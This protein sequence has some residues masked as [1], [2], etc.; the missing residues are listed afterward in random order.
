MRHMLLLILLA[1]PLVNSFVSISHVGYVSKH[2]NLEEQIPPAVTQQSVSCSERLNRRRTSL[3]FNFGFN[4]ERKDLVKR[5][6]VRRLNDDGSPVLVVQDPISKANI[7]LVGVSHN[8]AASANLVSKTIREVKPSATVLELCEDRFI[9]ISLDARIQ[10]RFNSTLTQIYGTKRAQLDEMEA[11]YKEI[12][13]SA[14]GAWRKFSSILSF[15]S[16]QGPVGGVFVFLGIVVG[17]LQK[18]ARQWNSEDT[19]VTVCDEFVVAMQEAE[20]LNIPVLLGDAPQNDTLNSIKKLFTSEVINPFKVVRNALFLGFSAFGIFAEES[21]PEV[22][23]YIPANVMQESQWISIPQVY[24][25]DK[26]L[27]RGLLPFGAIFVFTYLLGFVLDMGGAAAMD[28]IQHAGQGTI[29]GLPGFGSG[30]G[31]GG[32]LLNNIDN[33]LSEEVVTHEGALIPFWVYQAADVL[34]D[35][36]SLLL[37]IRMAKIIGTD[38]DLIIASKVKEAALK[39]PK[40]DIVVVIGM[41]HNNGVARWILSGQDPYN[42]EA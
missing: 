24:C 11:K 37:L 36:L 31:I 4:N 5:S 1:V 17:N 18:L 27:M 41:L 38:R 26:G 30:S 6:E 23:K 8:S 3:F 35:S 21:Y 16:S 12:E 40:K 13:G 20:T 10:P 39:Y 25:A 33:L 34:V 9:S 15:A 32:S 19:S 22:S 28:T 42:F 7:Y 14:S 2:V 29:T